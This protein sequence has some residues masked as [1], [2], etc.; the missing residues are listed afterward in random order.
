MNI[1]LKLTIPLINETGDTKE[2]KVDSNLFLTPYYATEDDILSTFSEVSENELPVLRKIIFNASLI[3]NRLTDK[4]EQLKILTPKMLFAL[5]RDYVICLATNELAKRLNASNLKS[6]TQ[7]KTLGDFTVSTSHT[8]D[9]TVLTKIFEDSSACL[10]DIERLIN[11]AEQDRILPVD[12]IKGRYNSANIQANDRLWWL[13]DLDGGSRVVD[14]YASNKFWY[15]G[16]QY[17]TATLNRKS[18]SIKNP[19]RRNN[20]E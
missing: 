18:L 13:K 2:L 20:E 1:N 12:F 15:Q 14:G 7:S 10:K 3:A 8:N 11:E 9:T 6:K 16:S 5:R 19:S 17:K 4:V